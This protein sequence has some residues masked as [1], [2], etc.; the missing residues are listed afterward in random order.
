METLKEFED[1]NE[2]K[3]INSN[4]DDP[5]FCFPLLIHKSNTGKDLFWQEGY[6]GKDIIY[7][8]GQVK[9]KVIGPGI[10]SY[11]VNTR[12]KTIRE[13]VINTMKSNYNK[14]IKSGY[15]TIDTIQD[16]KIQ[17]M[18]G[19]SYDKKTKKKVNFPAYVQP[20]LDGVRMIAHKIDGKI[21][22]DSFS[23]KSKYTYPIIEEQL[24]ELYNYVDND[25]NFDGELYSKNLTFDRISGSA[26][27][28]V[29]EID[30]DKDLMEYHIFDCFRIKDDRPFDER[31]KYF[32]SAYKKWMSSKPKDFIPKI[33]K[34]VTYEINNY[35]DIEDSL[36]Y[37]INEKY[38]GIMIK[39][40]A[41]DAPKDSE[42]YK[43]SLYE[44]KRSY[45]VLKYKPFFDKE[46][47]I[48]NVEEGEG[49]HK[50]LGI[51][52]VEIEKGKTISVI[53][54]M[55]H[56]ELKKW[57]EDPSL[58]VGKYATIEYQELTKNNLP[59]FAKIKAIRDYE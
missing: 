11:S 36:E 19:Y 31:I 29:S 1:F 26:R 34:V 14:K 59:R 57:L 18:K 52:V 6:N 35:D 42:R 32:S 16:E 37:F 9:G 58:I 17:G 40:I 7:Y 41:N 39:N 12:S 50:G 10:Y 49:T 51:P 4:F 53:P 47:L 21:Q 54:T 24:L 27:K 28:T 48:V 33:I 22:M 25:L 30:E 23:N 8:R 45:N 46:V 5:V 43:A 44:P 3:D 20:K 13:A 55:A 15:H 38:E 56:N 2:I